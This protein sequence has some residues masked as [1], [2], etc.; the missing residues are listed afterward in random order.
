[1]ESAVFVA[2][3]T[4]SEPAR[5]PKPAAAPRCWREMPLKRSRSSSAA[6]KPSWRIWLRVLILVD[7]ALRLATPN[8]L[9]ASTLP[10]LDLPAPWA[11]PDSAARAA[12]IASAGSDLPVRRRACRLGRSTSTTSTPALRNRRANPGNRAERSQPAHQLV[13]AGAGGLE[14]LHA[15]QPAD[16][17]ERGGHVHIKMGIDAA[18]NGGRVSSYDGH[19]H[20][21]LS[22]QVKGWHAPLLRAASV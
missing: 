5:G 7:R 4:G 6:V 12:S 21:F 10:S 2:K 18:R 15:Q 19:R 8:A 14:A 11:R 17:V 3:V 13:V 16:L 20:P 1:M 9:I 22:F